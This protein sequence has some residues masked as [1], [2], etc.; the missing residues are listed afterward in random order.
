MVVSLSLSTCRSRGP[1]FL[2]SQPASTY[3]RSSGHGRYLASPRPRC[4]TSA[5]E[6]HGVEPD[7][8]RELQR[9]HRLVG[10]ELHRGVDVLGG[11]EALHQREAGLV[12]HRDEDAVDDEARVVLARPPGLAHLL[13]QR[14]G[15]LRRSRRE[16][17]A[18]RMS[19]TSC[20]TGTGFMKCMPMT[21]SGRLVAAA[22]RVMGIDEV[23][24]AS[25]PPGRTTASRSWK[26]LLLQLLVLGD[27]LDGDV[28]VLRLGD[29]WSTV[30]R[31]SS[32]ALRS[33][34]VE[35]AL[36]DQLRRGRRDAAGALLHRLLRDVDQGDLEARRCSATCAMPAP[37]CPAPTTS[38]CSLAMARTRMPVLGRRD[39]TPRVPGGSIAQRDAAAT[40]GAV[41]PGVHPGRQSDPSQAAEHASGLENGPAGLK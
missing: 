1:V 35:L 21:A 32:A 31:R 12:E 33:R 22:M 36:L 27:R 41:S 8:V 16:V 3:C 28:D 20:I 18:P 26:M 34:V 17:A 2:P 15:A 39:Q 5:M 30:V 29:R 38:M 13:G 40:R 24:V 14:P 37:I 23:L 11:A 19:S 7:E 25:T 4:S 6:R 10:A 9:A